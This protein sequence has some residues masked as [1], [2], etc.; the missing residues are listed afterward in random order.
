[1]E[2]SQ[3]RSVATIGRW[4][5]TG[6]IY[7]APKRIRFGINGPPQA[8]RN[9][10]VDYPWGRGN[11]TTARARDLVGRV[12]ATARGRYCRFANNEPGRGTHGRGL[13][14]EGLGRGGTRLPERLPGLVIYRA[15]R[16]G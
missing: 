6:K 14:P 16:G 11:E 5:W 8:R 15:A 7:G 4:R 9:R 1:M 3:R 13:C 2:N 10:S 12:P